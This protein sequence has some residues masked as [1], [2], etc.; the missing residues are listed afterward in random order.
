[1]PRA[2][3]PH[4]VDMVAL[5][6]HRGL[7]YVLL[8]KRAKPPFLDRRA[9]PGGHVDEGEDLLAAAK[10]E[11][12]E[13]TT[14]GGGFPTAQVGTFGHPKRDPRGHV[15][16]TVFVGI[17]DKLEDVVP[18]DDAASVDWVPVRSLMR[19]DLAFDHF[20]ALQLAL[21]KVE[22][23]L[24]PMRLRLRPEERILYAANRWVSEA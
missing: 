21:T 19:E 17:F 18:A 8:I 9:L 10:R 4:T 20:F 23:V 5:C 22:V 15:I 3:L 1:M 14:L 13:E 11:L 2:S 7:L 16:N 24:S 6:L 12:L